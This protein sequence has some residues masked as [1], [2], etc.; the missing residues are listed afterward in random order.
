MFVDACAIISIFMQEETATSYRDALGAADAPFTSALAAFEAVIIL[1]RPD[2]LN[3]TYG[4]TLKDVL[5]WLHAYGID[6]REASDSNTVLAYAIT[7]AEG[8]GLGKRA[9]SNFDCF[10][11]AHAKAAGAPLL[12]LDALLRQTDVAT[13]P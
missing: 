2:R 7:V 12:T 8:H 6:L 9:L 11:Y 13:L 1:A 5:A 10:H 3:S 4:E